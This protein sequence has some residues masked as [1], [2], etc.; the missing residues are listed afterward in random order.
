MG[1]FL[2]LLSQIPHKNMRSCPWLVYLKFS[3]GYGYPHPLFAQKVMIMLNILSVYWCIS[4]KYR[5]SQTV[6][7]KM[8]NTTLLISSSIYAKRHINVCSGGDLCSPS[9]SNF[10]Q[11]PCMKVGFDVRISLA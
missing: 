3:L 4:D 7:K 11:T 2:V 8:E 10:S 1:Q 5:A 6:S 9:F